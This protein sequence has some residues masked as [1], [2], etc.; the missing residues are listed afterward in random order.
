LEKN[1]LSIIVPAYNEE[2]GIVSFLK[3]LRREVKNNKNVEVELIVVNDG[4]TDKTPEQLE[5]IPDIT[6]LHHKHNYGYGA[7]L[8]T[9]F[10]T[11]RFENI[12]IIDADNTYNSEDIFRLLPNIEHNDMVVGSRTGIVFEKLRLRRFAKWFMIRLAEYLAKSRIP[13]LNS[14]L[15]IIDKTAL[16]KYLYLLPDT[17]SFTTTITLAILTDMGSVHYEP[18]EIKE[19]TGRS[20]IKPIKDSMLFFYQILTTILC[21][22]PIRIF[23]PIS[24]LFLLLGLF[25]G[26]FSYYFLEKFMDTTTI[27]CFITSLQFLGISLI[28]ELIVRLSKKN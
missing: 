13:D 24:F 18:I 5:S 28:A 21:F 22:Q 10:R 11:A 4:S 15:R 25:I 14:G 2:D 12:A 20:K 8:K 3:E 17:F 23:M 19:R 26:A 6:V 27:V 9:G 16:E 1:F 7:A